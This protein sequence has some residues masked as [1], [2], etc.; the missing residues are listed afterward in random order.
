MR[1]KL[2]RDGFSVPPP[3]QDRNCAR[4][5]K[6]QVWQLCTGRPGLCGTGTAAAR[7]ALLVTRQWWRGQLS[8]EAFQVEKLRWP[9][10]SGDCAA[11][12]DEGKQRQLAARAW[13]RD[14]VTLHPGGTGEVR[15]EGGD[16]GMAGSLLRQQR[17]IKTGG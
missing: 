15:A 13:D 2:R 12:R 17:V 1:L 8:W 3:P 16:L 6:R 4:L 5:A 10:A 11:G 7:A 14:G 9:W